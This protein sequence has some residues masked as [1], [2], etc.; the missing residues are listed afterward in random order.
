EGELCLSTPDSLFAVNC[1]LV[2][3]QETDS[4]DSSQDE[5][6][7]QN[8]ERKETQEVVPCVKV[9][10]VVLTPVPL[11][12]NVPVQAAALEYEQ[13]LRAGDEYLLSSLV[14]RYENILKNAQPEGLCLC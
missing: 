13:I 10:L 8:K 1:A 5:E 14:E 7:V 3:V 4:D 9:F 12:N 2:V 6:A 11:S